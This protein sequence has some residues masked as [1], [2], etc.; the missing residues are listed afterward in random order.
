MTEMWEAEIMSRWLI[1]IA[2][3]NNRRWVAAVMVTM[4]GDVRWWT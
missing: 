1:V 4:A 2:R 3:L